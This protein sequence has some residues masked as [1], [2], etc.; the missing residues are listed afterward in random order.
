MIVY[1]KNVISQLE[2][3]PAAVEEL[4][5]SSTLKDRKFRQEAEKLNVPVLEVPRSRLDKLTNGAAHNGV[6]ARV[7][8]FPP[9]HWKSC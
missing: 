9:I 4:Y 7:G 2:N 8:I 6:A 1:G 3:D 5:V